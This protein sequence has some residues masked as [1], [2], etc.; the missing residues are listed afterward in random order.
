MCGRYTL[1]RQALLVDELEA[2]LG[3]AAE[4]AWWKPRY[5]VAPTQPAPVVIQR[6]GGRR[7]QMMRRGQGPSRAGRPG[8][9]A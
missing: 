1:T 2:S 4:S 6:D 7:I 9:P 5:N 3:V 8:P